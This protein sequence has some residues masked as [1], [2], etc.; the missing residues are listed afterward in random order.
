MVQFGL[1]TQFDQLA[2]P[3]RQKQAWFAMPNQQQFQE[4]LLTKEKMDH[5]M[6]KVDY[7][8]Q[9]F[10]TAVNNMVQNQWYIIDGYDKYKEGQMAKLASVADKKKRETFLGRLSAAA[11]ERAENIAE[12]PWKDQTVAE[13]IFQTAWQIAW[14]GADVVGETLITGIKKAAEITGIKEGMEQRFNN[15]LQDPTVV[16][17]LQFASQKMEDYEKRA[18]ENRRLADNLEATLN[19]WD[20]ALNFAWAGIAGKVWQQTVWK[21]TDIAGAVVKKIPTKFNMPWKGLFRKRVGE[22][23]DDIELWTLSQISWLDPD[24]VKT[25]LKNPE[26]ALDAVNN[27]ENIE[28]VVSELTK[29]VDDLYAEKGIVGQRYSEFTRWARAQDIIDMSNAR[30]AVDDILSKYGITVKNGKLDFTWSQ[31]GSNTNRNA[32]K[33]MYDEMLGSD[34]PTISSA[35]NAR[36]RVD[37]IMWEA[38]RTDTMSKIKS[39]MRKVYDEVLGEQVPDI[40]KLDQEF[41]PIAELSSKIKRDFFTAEW[42]PKDNILTLTKWLL[43][44]SRAGKLARVREIYP[45]IVPRLEKLQLQA[46]LARSLWQKTWTYTRAILSWGAFIA[47]PI[48]GTIAWAI[49][50]SP[51]TVINILSKYAKLRKKAPWIN[52][53]IEKIEAKK[54][55][56]DDVLE[57]VAELKDN[58]G[59]SVWDDL[60]MVETEYKLDTSWW[61]KE[62]VKDV[63]G[64][65]LDEAR[66]YKS[67]DDF[68]RKMR[69][70]ASQLKEYDPNFRRY[71]GENSKVVSDVV[72]LPSDTVVTV[73]RWI[74]ADEVIWWGINKLDYVTTDYDDALSYVGDPTKVYEKDVPIRNLVSEYPDEIEIV[75][76]DSIQS[77]ELIYDPDKET[78]II[79]DDELRNIR[80]QAN[81]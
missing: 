32:I 20:F 3:T 4:K 29:A 41:A 78:T 74:D 1:T 53:A 73:Y 2:D 61:L 65:L 16:Q 23:V 51:K 14:F 76:G 21:A 71:V 81:K 55:L 5:I 34:T 56:T 15:L 31:I 67:A 33:N 6:R 8:E 11:W 60:K 36:R 13:D 26:F 37:D 35:Y 49:M 54:P 43:A 66:K 45:D 64:Y 63:S 44:D 47:N 70:S 79:S 12:I 24:T 9:A 28:D 59:N 25:A 7:N 17:W 50:F 18:S 68:V 22:I 38:N 58:K 39:D 57:K 19:V 52:D 40:K 27:P 62:T 42:K 80:E 69:W 46:D 30:L 75:D 72:D 77:Y 48:V 10:N